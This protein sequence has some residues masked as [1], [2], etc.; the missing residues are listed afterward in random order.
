MIKNSRPAVVLLLLLAVALFL[1]GF[2]FGKTVEQVNQSYIPLQPPST[3][4]TTLLP[5]EPP[6]K[7]NNYL[8]P[9]CGITFLYPA[10]LT[11]EPISS[12]AAQLTKA[13]ERIF[14][15][16]NPTTVKNSRDVLKNIQA[17]KAQ[18]TNGQIVPFYQK[19]AHTQTWI[20]FN[21]LLGKSVLFE[22]SLN[23]SNLILKTTEFIK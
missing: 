3:P 20:V 15:S 12:Q 5:T 8:D 10:N 6:V 21:T 7:F 16:C 19:D 14:I 2:R 11:K 1:V 17:T 9:Q 4:T 23:L 22:S 18:T 13:S